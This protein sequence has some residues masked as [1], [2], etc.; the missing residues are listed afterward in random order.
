M[1]NDPS[2]RVREIFGLVGGAKGRLV[3][4]QDWSHAPAPTAVRAHVRLA[5]QKQ[6]ADEQVLLSVRARA[7]CC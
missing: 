1:Q 2:C 3:R 4:Q 7:A 5:E 6:G